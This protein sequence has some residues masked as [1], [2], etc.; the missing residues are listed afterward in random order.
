MN[1]VTI[2]DGYVAR[3]VVSQPT[4]IKVWQGKVP[5]NKG[6]KLFIN[7]ETAEP[8]VKSSWFRRLLRR[9]T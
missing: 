4:Y 3:V 5:I 2:K 8:T 6:D 7:V 9:L 1:T